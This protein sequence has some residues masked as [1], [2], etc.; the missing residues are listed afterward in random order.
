MVRVLLIL[1]GVGVVINALTFLMVAHYVSQEPEEVPVEAPPE[2]PSPEETQNAEILRRLT[3]LG[4]DLKGMN[5]KFTTLERNLGQLSKKVEKLAAPAPA[6]PEMTEEPEGTE[7]EQPG[8]EL[9][10][11]PEGEPPEN[12]SAG[13]GGRTPA[14]AR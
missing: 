12:A 1:V 2:T 14:I 5:L 9:E 4:N 11:V 3:T 13:S 7:V 8:G 10:G 6:A